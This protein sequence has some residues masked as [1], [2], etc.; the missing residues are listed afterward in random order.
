[1]C[2]LEARNKKNN[3]QI[4][5]IIAFFLFFLLKNLQIFL[6]LP[7]VLVVMQLN[8]LFCSDTDKL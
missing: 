3:A 6:K 1:M 4:C 8:K 2:A 5:K 7:D